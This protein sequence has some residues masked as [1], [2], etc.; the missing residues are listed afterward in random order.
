MM[1]LV[2]MRSAEHQAYREC[3]DAISHDWS[4]LFAELAIVPILVPNAF[5]DT[6][7][8]L[9]LGARGLLLTGG[10]DLGTETAPTQRDV[11]ERT[12]LAA[13]GQRG[14]PVFGVCRGLQVVNRFFG[15]GLS[16]TLPES[17]VGEHDVDFADGRSERVNSFHTDGV[18]REQLAPSLVVVAA[19]RSGVVEA[20][21]HPTL[22]VSAVQWHP[23]R[24]NPS[25][26]LD[27]VLLRNWLAQC[28]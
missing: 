13:A 4:R 12:L 11:V 21:R 15:G 26:S 2:T 1:I 7:I 28:A 25:A 3:R 5:G 24:P 20:L 10:D 17:H 22:S 16:R 23:E 14:L 27:R 18:M 9:S 19:T 8:F 6:S